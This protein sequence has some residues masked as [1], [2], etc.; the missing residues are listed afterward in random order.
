MN[1]RNGLPLRPFREL[2]ERTRRINADI[3]RSLLQLHESLIVFDPSNFNHRYIVLC[4]HDNNEMQTS[5]GRRRLHW[6]R[7]SLQPFDF[8]R[9]P[10]LSP[11]TFNV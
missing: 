4:P 10:D 1:D 11:A 9:Y 8:K 5:C 3:S 2:T 7:H 6:L